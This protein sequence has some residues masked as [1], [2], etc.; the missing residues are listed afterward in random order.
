MRI[1]KAVV[2]AVA[3]TALPFASLAL[4]GSA[5]AATPSCTPNFFNNS[6][7]FLDCL[8][9]FNQ[10]FGLN[11]VWDVYHAQAKPG[12]PV[13]LFQNTTHDGAEDFSFYADGSVCDFYQAGLV[14][15]AVVL[16]YGGGNYCFQNGSGGPNDFFAFEAEYT[17]YGRPSGLCVGVPW[18]ARR[19]TPVLLEPC[20]ETSKTVW[21]LDQADPQPQ[22]SPS[23]SGLP[24][25][26][27]ALINGSDRNFSHPFVLNYPGN[28]AAPWD[29]PRPVLT[30]DNLAIYSNGTVFDNQMWGLTYAGPQ[31]SFPPPCFP[32]F[33]P[34]SA[35]TASGPATA[36]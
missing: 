18:T 15:A 28:G 2:A 14:S 24:D 25:G 8:T 13:I 30:T 23:F 5:S 7:T 16:H 9:P 12:T 4:G 29:R 22:C 11:Y 17:P 33:G 34:L 26:Y 20:G 6:N 21:I 10:E 1:R 3:A 19:G 36:R 32:L 35:G 27:L 31:Q